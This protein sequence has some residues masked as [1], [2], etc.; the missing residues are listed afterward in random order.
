M[1]EQTKRLY[2]MLTSIYSLK[3]LPIYQPSTLPIKLKRK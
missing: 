1:Y 3:F 2:Q